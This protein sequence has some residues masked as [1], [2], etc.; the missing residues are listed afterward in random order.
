MQHNKKK[1]KTATKSKKNYYFYLNFYFIFKFIF[2]TEY[3]KRIY[4]FWLE[5]SYIN[6]SFFFKGFPINQFDWINPARCNMVKFV[7][8]V[9]WTLQIP[10]LDLVSIKLFFIHFLYSKQTELMVTKEGSLFIILFCMI[11]RF[12]GKIE[13]ILKKFKY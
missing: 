7:Y 5:S 10:I 3:E 12:I 1:T 13:T 4:N 2:F 11:N 8:F 6:F 9:N